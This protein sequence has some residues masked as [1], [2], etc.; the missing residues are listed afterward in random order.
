MSSLSAQEYYFPNDLQTSTPVLN[1]A[2]TINA[3]F[4]KAELKQHSCKEK[5]WLYGVRGN[6]DIIVPSTLYLGA[7][8]GY[9]FG[10]LKG[11]TSNTACLI[12][13]DEILG[14]ELKSK[15]SDLWG[16]LRA[17]FTFGAVGYSL[18][19]PFIVGGYEK[20][21][22]NFVSPS[23]LELKHSFSYG[24]VGAGAISSF[25]LSSNLSFGCNFKLKWMFAS[26]LKTSG[27][28]DLYDKSISS[29]GSFH[30]FVEL[31]FSF[32]Y[33]PQFIASIAPCYE[34]KNYDKHSYDWSGKEK[35]S[36]HMWGLLLQLTSIF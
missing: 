10:T 28:P 6:Y 17:G 34:Y 2:G 22:N 31:P 24:Y 30:A 19:T 33:C 14:N 4:G 27:E 32:I 11:D 21:T 8:A 7:E 35:A 26:T 5:G 23:P 1:Q 15:Y 12:R 9:K 20:E 3:L 13:G 16:E 29:A 25:A 18:I 36:F